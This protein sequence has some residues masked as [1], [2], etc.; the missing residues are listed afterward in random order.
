MF[1]NWFKKKKKQSF[2]LKGKDA[3]NYID[4]LV[5]RFDN[6]CSGCGAAVERNGVCRV[7]GV[8]DIVIPCTEIDFGV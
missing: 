8:R 6:R 1:G 7:C 4:T 3:Q 2:V 5:S